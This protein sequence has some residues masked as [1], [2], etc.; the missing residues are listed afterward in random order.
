MTQDR[1]FTEY[2]DNDAMDCVFDIGNMSKRL[3]ASIKVAS[4]PPKQIS[5]VV[6][7]ETQDLPPIK[8][9]QSKGRHSLVSPE[10]LSERWQIGLEQSKETLKRTTQRVIQSAVLMPLARR[11]RADRMFQTKRLAGKWASDTMDG[12]VKLLDGNQEYAQVF[13]NGGFF[14]EFYPMARKADAGLA[15]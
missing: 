15:L 4:P 8:T 5:Q 1:A 10:D 7:T 6:E 14:A 13:S 2:P 11:Y 12:R 3:I 9:F